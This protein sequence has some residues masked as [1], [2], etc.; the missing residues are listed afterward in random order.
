MSV[1]AVLARELRAARGALNARVA[2]A[3]VQS[4][5]DPAALS[6]FLRE[7]LDP[8]AE[9]VEAAAPERTAAVVDAAFGMA[10]TLT[11]QRL[12]GPGARS[13]V[14]DET[15][16]ELGAPYA[17]LIAEQPSAVL[18][19]LSNAAL[20][21]AS[22]PG[23]RVERW[24]ELMVGLAPH[25]TFDTYRALGQVAAWRAGVA[26]YREGALRAADTLEDAVALAAVGAAGGAWPAVRAAF[27]ANR[28]WSPG[29]G[30][31]ER[32]IGGF[33]GFGGPFSEPPEVAA[34]A[35]GL[36][37]RSG[38]RCHLLIVDGYGATLHPSTPQAFQA[39]VA[40]PVERPRLRGSTVEAGDR[41]VEVDLPA[42]GLK[43]AANASTL[44]VASP[45]SH[46]VRLYPW[47]LP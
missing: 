45:F 11:A 21:I 33:S 4:G 44:A 9:A 32:R 29:D 34:D 24:R 30:A 20:R 35:E 41:T 18:G 2:A 39:A 40:R 23:A 43:A 6:S 1:S 31:A 12:A 27:A 5:F 8:L 28:W 14:V 22:T 25:A 7:R 37:V 15:W 47:R 38:D 16:A 46:I 26:H 19:A 36:L 17:M 10:L 3:G 42:E 13:P